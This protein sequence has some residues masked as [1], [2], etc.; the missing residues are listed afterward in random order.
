MPRIFFV[1]VAWLATCCGA[2]AVR[3]YASVPEDLVA[4]RAMYTKLWI[5][6]RVHALHETVLRQKLTDSGPLRFELSDIKE[7]QISDIADKFVPDVVTK[8]SVPTLSFATGSWV[9]TQRGGQQAQAQEASASW[10][11]S[12]S[13]SPEGTNASFAKLFETGAVQRVFSRYVSFVVH[14][15]CQDPA[16]DA[17]YHALV[18]FG[19]GDDGK[20]L[21]LPMDHFV[22]GS[23]L[24]AQ[25]GPALFP[26][27]LL[28]EPWRSDLEVMRFL[29]WLAAQPG[30]SIEPATNLCCDPAGVRCG[31]KTKTGI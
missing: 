4:V 7:G 5:A 24:A 27:P 30:C 16:F 17:T 28:V 10:T 15:T 29:H 12:P 3:G 19:T 9:L 20:P 22:G 13:F 21:V 31:I 18:L 11:T 8:P 26:Q 2:G 1:S 23:A 14:F 25:V 6:W